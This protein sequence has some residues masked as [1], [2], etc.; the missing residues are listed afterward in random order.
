MADGLILKPDQTIVFIGDSITDAGR[1]QRAYRPFGNGYVHFTANYLLAKY[2][3]LNFRIFNTG[4]NGNTMRDLE[5]RWERDCLSHKP[6]VLSVLI[7]IND[8]WQTLTAGRESEGAEVREYESTY[9]RLLAAVKQQGDCQFILMEPFMFCD[10]AEDRM[11]RDL[12]AYIKAVHNL[13]EQFDAALVPLQSAID[14][15][16]KTVA[17]DKWSDD[18]VHPY[19]WAHCWISQQWIEATKV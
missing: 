10:D 11:F 2:P 6:D 12:P 14:E 17:S 3:Q 1:L 13:A 9:Q 5:R 19:I 7:G 4:I 18:M 8:L 16:I 15:K